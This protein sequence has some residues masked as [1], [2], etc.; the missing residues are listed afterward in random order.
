VSKELVRRAA[1]FMNGPPDATDAELAEVFTPG[2]VLDCTSRVFNPAVYHGFDGLRQFRAEAA[3]AWESVEVKPTS[4]TE[5]G[6][7]ILVNAHVKT[8]GRG[9]GVELDQPSAWVWTVRGDRLY[10]CR[11]LPDGRLA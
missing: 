9:S 8:R 6:D 10:H 2:V 7:E 11:L 3:E 4:I 1:E 5:E